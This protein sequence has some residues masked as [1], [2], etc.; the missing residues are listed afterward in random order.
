MIVRKL[1]GM[2]DQ[3]QLQASFCCSH[4]VCYCLHDDDDDDDDDSARKQALLA[5]YIIYLPG[6]PT[7]NMVPLPSSASLCR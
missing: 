2:L 4:P 6:F 7:C 3:Q 1:L 5:M